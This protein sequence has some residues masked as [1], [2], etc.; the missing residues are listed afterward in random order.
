MLNINNNIKVIE[1]MVK[2]EID[3]IFWQKVKS[4]TQVSINTRFCGTSG[5]VGTY[6]DRAALLNRRKKFSVVMRATS[7]ALTPFTV[8]TV[9][10]V[11]AV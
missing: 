1:V 9:W 8:A 4:D 3:F 10:A 7:S 11:R 6:C 5:V 2:H